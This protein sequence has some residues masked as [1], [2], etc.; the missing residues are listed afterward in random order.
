MNK[1]NKDIYETYRDL[2][3][4]QL[5]TMVE[6]LGYQLG[7]KMARLLKAYLIKAY[8]KLEQYIELKRIYDILYDVQ[9]VRKATASRERGLP[10]GSIDPLY[11]ATLLNLEKQVTDHLESLLEHMREYMEIFKPIRGIGPRLSGGFIANTMIRYVK[12]T[13]GELEK[14]SEVQQ[15][16]KQKTKFGNYLVPSIRSIFAFATISKYRA[17]SGY[18]MGK[19]GTAQ[20]RIRGKKLEFNDRMQ[21]LLW[22]ARKQ[23][24]L[25]GDVYRK[26]YDEYKEFYTKHSRY[27][28][29]LKD[30][31]MCPR[32]EPCKERLK[33]RAKALDR[34]MKKFP[35]KGHL[36][37]MAERKMIKDF[38]RD[39]YL[40]W[41]RLEG[42]PP[43]PPYDPNHKHHN[44]N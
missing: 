24:V 29:A 19:D 36:N 15:N 16:Y 43:P 34:E 38:Q 41:W 6:N 25:Q 10:K 26:L 3:D 17:W 27:A 1:E 30:P 23:F 28:L 8:G 11:S 35:C 32:Y 22:K 13:P 7:S 31:E 2:I 12:V 9:E 37:N 5:K 14:C 42:I 39:I 4:G 33:K 20:R 40:A 21:V 18:G 44:E